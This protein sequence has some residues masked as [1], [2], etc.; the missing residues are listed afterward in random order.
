MKRILLTALILA[1][2]LTGCS[3]L[4]GSPA[5]DDP[6][7]LEF[8]AQ[9]WQ[10]TCAGGKDSIDA[11]T[12]E[13]FAQLIY[14]ETNG[15]V[16]V[17]YSTGR[18][19][20]DGD[21]DI[22]LYSSLLWTQQDPRFGVL[23]L[24]FLFSSEATAA[25]ALDGAGGDALTQLLLEQGQVCIGIGSGGFRSLTN[26]SRAVASPADMA[27]LRIRVED[28]PILQ[29]A[30]ALWGVECITADWPLVYTALRTG[31]YDGQEMPVETASAAAIQDVQTHATRWTALY[32]S[33]FLC[34]DRSLYES[35]SPSLQE[36][37]SRCG[38]KTEA[39]QRQLMAES[40]DSILSRWRRAGVTVTELAPE[41]A[42]A[43]RIA[44]QPCYD[45]FAREVSA[46][47]AATFAG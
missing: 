27:D 21:A 37:V 44:A 38:E 29:E 47:L 11:K 32:S 3:G 16:S 14:R 24:P 39:Y 18:A 9:T 30:Y 45:R 1:V 19:P 15:A 8:E 23:T 17:E 7:L 40:T 12:A 4:S 36:I 10:L 31:T 46:D 25:A 33:V 26:S 6:I 5:D 42:A 41:A 13:Y 22:S 20:E 43:F 34:M 2:F 35:L 28:I